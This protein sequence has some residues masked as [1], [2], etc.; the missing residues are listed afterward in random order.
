MVER[1]TA[2]QTPAVEYQ[3]ILHLGHDL[4]DQNFQVSV[5]AIVVNQAKKGFVEAQS[6][7][8]TTLL[9]TG[10]SLRSY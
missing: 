7:L 6:T 4:L 8:C 3:D 5:E 10:F 9:S 2:R 1:I